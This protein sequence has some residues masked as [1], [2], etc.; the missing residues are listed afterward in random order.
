LRDE[1]RSRLNTIYIFAYFIGGSLG[2][3]LGAYAWSI[4]RWNGVCLV[5]GAMLVL[6]LVVYV[7]RSRQAGV[8]QA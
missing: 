8:K 6:A 5:G 2:S 7:V 4:A 3:T 1:L